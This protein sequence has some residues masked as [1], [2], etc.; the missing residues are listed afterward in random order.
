M[1]IYTVTFKAMGSHMQAWL[2]VP[3]AAN[4][5]V[6]QHVP[7]WFEAWEAALSRFRPTSELRHLN[8]HAG[9]WVRVSK[10]MLGVVQVAV[11]A[12]RMT[13][14]LFNPLILPALEA[15]GYDHS[16]DPAFAPQ[17]HAYADHVPTW[18]AI[19]INAAQCC[20][21]LPTG[22]RLDLGGMAKGWAA[23]RAAQ[24]L[25][26]TGPCLVDAGGDMAARGAP[27]GADGWEVTAPDDSLI[28]LRDAAV[29]TSGTDYRHWAAGDRA[30]HHLIDP[31]T[32]SPADSN[33]LTATVVA[34]SA[35]KAEAWA[36][37]ALISGAMPELPTL[38]VRRDGSTIGNSTFTQLRK[39]FLCA[40]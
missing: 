39:E 1:A 22:S 19:Q 40:T 38:F 4:A 36:K 27:E 37:A 17:P 28:V 7:V 26:E 3:T 33:V 5:D 10:L 13:N 16:F 29:A 2:D 31:R 23:Q 11:D 6:L 24:W 34:D 9:L 30:Y 21:R 25:Y 14:S 18:E 15:A 32:G 12:A 8:R 35:V 20:V